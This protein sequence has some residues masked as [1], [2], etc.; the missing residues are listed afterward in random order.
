MSFFVE[1]LLQPL[2]ADFA[3]E[4]EA[5][6]VLTA[7]LQKLERRPLRFAERKLVQTQV[8][9][10]FKRFSIQVESKI[11]QQ[12]LMRI[13]YDY[14]PGVSKLGLPEP[15]NG[16][17]DIKDGFSESF[18]SGE[19]TI[20]T[21][22]GDDETC[23]VTTNST[24]AP[25]ILRQLSSTTKYFV[26]TVKRHRS[27]L[28]TSY[29]LYVDEAR[30]TLQ[31]KSVVKS[32]QLVYGARKSK[33]GMSGQYLLW[34]TPD[35][36][37]WRE[38][39]AVGKIS[40]VN[41]SSY[42]AKGLGDTTAVA[43]DRC[44]PPIAISVHSRGMDKLIHMKSIALPGFEEDV[45]DSTLLTALETL[46]TPASSTMSTVDKNRSSPTKRESK[47]VASASAQH[48]SPDWLVLRS[49]LPHREKK[50]TFSVN[51]SKNTR[52]RVRAA[53]RK[54]VVVECVSG[55][56]V[57]HAAVVEWVSSESSEPPLFQLGKIS[58]DVFALDFHTLSLFQAF[59]LALTA[60]DQ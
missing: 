39:N 17:Y 7:L 6:G 35:S 26:C 23:S 49:Q 52:P 37:D 51:F 8:N 44:G 27:T 21:A 50:G 46:I 22:E 45:T 4:A 28:W 47:S 18:H 10:I 36:K 24:L 11:A 13:S 12:F 1:E 43:K 31:G 15:P 16:Q 5:V 20:E 34:S 3:S 53:S 40:R 41:R 33:S 19:N 9:E 25:S 57:S 55:A 48:I 42:L 2:K 54:N 60:F 38:K 30:E 58:E 56:G 29:R 59:S 32:D 14:L